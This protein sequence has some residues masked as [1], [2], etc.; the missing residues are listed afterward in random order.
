MDNQLKYRHFKGKIYQV[1]GLAKHTETLEKLVIYH[2]VGDKKVIWARPKLKIFDKV[3][4]DGK[5]YQGLKKFNFM[6]RVI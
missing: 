2:P 5:K 4:I 6:T 1:I 3:N